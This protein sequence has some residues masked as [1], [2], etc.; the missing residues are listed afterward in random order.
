MYQKGVSAK[1]IMKTLV[2]R[3]KWT[4]K[5]S[6][7]YYFVRMLGR[8]GGGVGLGL[9]FHGMDPSCAYT[10]YVFK[11]LV[12]WIKLKRKQIK[13]GAGFRAV[14]TAVRSSS[15]Y[16]AGSSACLQESNELRWSISLNEGTA[17][18]MFSLLSVFCCF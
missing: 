15:E 12:K 6:L 9:L 4:C 16:K 17:P 1:K 2:L 7:L 13:I 5:S 14:G 10:V 18:T 8:L 11:H 3:H